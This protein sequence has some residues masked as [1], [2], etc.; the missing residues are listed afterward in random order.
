[1]NGT[2]HRLDLEPK[3]RGIKQVRFLTLLLFVSGA[4]N[5]ALVTLFVY[6]LFNDPMSPAYYE[7]SSVSQSKSLLITEEQRGLMDTILDLKTRSFNELVVKLES[8][9]SI[10]EGYKERDLALACL[11]S[12]H[13]FNIQRALAGY[14]LQY[15]QLLFQDSQFPFNGEVSIFPGLEDHQYRSLI[16]YARTERWPLTSQGLFLLLKRERDLQQFDPSLESAFFLMPEFT[17]VE[18][19][20][21]RVDSEVGRHVILKIILD[22]DWSLV[23]DFAHQ[24][25]V[26]QDL[27]SAQRQNF[28]LAYVLRGSSIA[29][30][31]LL[32]T[33]G[34]FATKQ[35][36]DQQVIGILRALHD[37]S[38][39]ALYF[40]MDLL[41]SPR[42][43]SVWRSAATFLYKS[44]GLPLPEPYDHMAA[45]S[46]FIPENILTSK[47]SKDENSVL[48]EEEILDI[49]RSRKGEPR[50]YM[51]QD[52]DNLWRIAQEYRI[53][54]D[55]LMEVNH[56]NSPTI[57]PGT[58]LVIPPYSE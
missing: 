42:S 34:V 19:L 32:Q 44:E 11:V 57:Q 49:E 39:E 8:T 51:V 26:S 54:M 31:L 45:L 9:N 36:S 28:L 5:I 16:H 3:S 13:Y 55:Q 27:S 23:D 33:D 4:L 29:A 14:P 12:F 25:R 53:D 1:M 43:D 46:R 15:R 48:M 21:S 2:K 10:E 52:G 40:A 41:T 38:P 22:G 6:F 50:M 30:Q 56:L 18:S 37:V 17:S 20:F 35:L 24:Q 58:T 7:S 47:V